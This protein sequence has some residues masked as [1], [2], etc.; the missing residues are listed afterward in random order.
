[1][2]P[3]QPFP[4]C[5]YLNPRSRLFTINYFYENCE[6]IRRSYF[7]RMFFPVYWKLRD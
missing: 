2:G 7:F 4:W 3:S 6:I 5:D 1:M